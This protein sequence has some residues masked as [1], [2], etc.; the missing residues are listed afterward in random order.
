MDNMPFTACRVGVDGYF[1]YNGVPHIAGKFSEI[2]QSDNADVRSVVPGI[3]EL[4]VFWCTPS[5]QKFQP[6]G[7]MTEIWKTDNNLSADPGER[8][9]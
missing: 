4:V 7:V 8:F 6:D 2:F 3:G 1:L 9:E 5:E